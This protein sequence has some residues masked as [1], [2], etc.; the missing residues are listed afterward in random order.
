MSISIHGNTRTRT[1]VI[2]RE[3]SNSRS[4]EKLYQDR[5]WL[6]RLDFLKRVDFM[7]KEK[8]DT[9]AE[10]LIIVVQEKPVYE[11]LPIIDNH[12][13][14]GWLWGV[15]LIQ[16]NLWGRREA[17]SFSYET[18][19]RETFKALWQEPWFGN[20]LHLI[21][22]LSFQ[23]SQGDYLYRDYSPHFSM[24]YKKVEYKLGK[25]FGRYFNIGINFRYESMHTNDNKVTLS[26]TFDDELTS[27]GIFVNWDNRDWP[28]YPAK[29]LLVKMEALETK[30]NLYAFR[31]GSVEINYFQHIKNRH[32]LAFQFHY[33]GMEGSIPVYKRL[34]LGGTKSLRGYKAGAFG[35]NHIFFSSSEYRFPMFYL[36]HPEEGI[37]LG[38]LGF[39][40]WDVGSNWYGFNDLK[41]L[42]FHHSAGLGIH[43]ILDSWNL[44]LE[45]GQVFK[46]LGYLTAGTSFKF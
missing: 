21:S 31:N 28:V 7:V 40:F 22:E 8:S 34:H 24:D 3:L 1:Q 19:K 41:A 4:L 46:G 6:Q 13:V 44:R 16:R 29:G 23:Y 12:D 33:S 20:K 10:K 37:H 17:L 42:Q 14:Y 9:E 25:G 45:Y 36:R 35:G 43:A 26:Q 39:V 11:V 38:W 5:A 32:I 2:L 30:T 18:G 27:Q 15:Q